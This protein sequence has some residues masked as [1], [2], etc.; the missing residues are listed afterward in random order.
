M[1]RF[2]L[3]IMRQILGPLTLLTFGF[4][5]VIW[6]TQ[7][8]RFVDLIVNKGLSLGLFLYMTLLLLPS[9]LAII[10]PVALFAAVLYA[11]HQLISDREIVVLKAATLSHAR[12]AGPAL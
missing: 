5:G 1:S 2:S 3:Y 7:S 10:L 6:L 12:L 11:Y 4:T 9:L 8:L